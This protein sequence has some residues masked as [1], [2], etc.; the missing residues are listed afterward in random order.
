MIGVRVAAAAGHDRITTTPVEQEMRV[1]RADA[2]WVGAQV[3]LLAAIGIGL[4]LADGGPGRIDAPALRWVGATL[5]VGCGAIGV[6][7][8]RQLGRQLVVQPTP[9]GDGSVVD[10][11]LY[12]IVR[13]PIYLAVLT[14]ATGVALAWPSVTGLVLVVA[15]AVLLG[16]KSAHEERLLVAAHPDYADYCRRVRWKLVPGIR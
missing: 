13:H 11:G 7:A 15:L 2:A 10:T 3:V 14:G 9:I 12:G 4:P 16:R 1:D 8:M 6:V 5:L